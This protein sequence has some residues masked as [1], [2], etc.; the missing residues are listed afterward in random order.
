MVFD[1]NTMFQSK[2]KEAANPNPLFCGNMKN[3]LRVRH[4]VPAE[5]SDVPFRA[6]GWTT[7]Q[8][9]STAFAIL[10][11]CLLS[12]SKRATRNLALH[13]TW[14]CCFRVRLHREMVMRN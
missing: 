14:H 2:G 4:P 5:R 10:Q 6:R 3:G 12:A 7:A 13:C 9:S 1:T 11:Q 8:R